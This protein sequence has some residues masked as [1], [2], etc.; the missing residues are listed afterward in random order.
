MSIK[1]LAETHNKYIISLEHQLEPVPAVKATLTIPGEGTTYTRK[2]STLFVT[3][4]TLEQAEENAVNR[5]VAMMLGDEQS[6]SLVK[7]FDMFDISST[8]F[9]AKKAVPG[10]ISNSGENNIPAKPEIFG[11]KSTIYVFVEGKQHRTVSAYATGADV[12]EVEKEAIK[13]AVTKVMGE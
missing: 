7:A 12:S 1:K 3:G 9:V 11:V 5:A 10:F 13:N 6:Q 4:N 2:V 8:Q